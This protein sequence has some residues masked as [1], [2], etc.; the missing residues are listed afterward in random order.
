MPHTLLRRFGLILLLL[1]TM[2]PYAGS[3]GKQ[4]ARTPAR[5][6]AP[7]GSAKFRAR[8]DAVLSDARA[9]KGYWSVLVEDAASGEVLYALNPQRYFLPASNTKLFTTAFAMATLGP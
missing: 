5:R 9:A 1:L 6:P 4:A 3:Q 2:P 8:V 7:A